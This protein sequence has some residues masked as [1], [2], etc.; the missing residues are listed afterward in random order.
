MAMLAVMSLARRIY[1]VDQDRFDVKPDRSTW[2]EMA[3]VLSDCGYRV[4]ILTWGTSGYQPEGDVRIRYFPAFDMLWLFRAS[5]LLNIL[6]WL[7]RHSSRDDLIIIHP[8]GLYIA[9]VLRLLGRRNIHL[10]VRTVPVEV[11]SFKRRLDR[12]LYWELPMRFLR[13]AARGHSFITR[14]L[15]EMVEGEFSVTIRDFSIWSSGV[16]TRRFSRESKATGFAGRHTLF[17]HGTISKDRGID[18]VVL[19]MASISQNVRRRIRFVLVGD[20]PD[21]AAIEQLASDLGLSE[22]VHFA[23]KHPY[24][25]IPAMVAD[26]SVCICPLPDRPEWNVSSPIKVFEFMAAGRPMILTPIPAHLDVAKSRDFVVWTKGDQPE[27]YR[28]AIEH[29]FA[30]LSALSEAARSAPAVAR[31]SFDW[32][33]QGQYLADY[34]DKKFG[35]PREKARAV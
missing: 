16:N 33:V 3:Q 14:R 29:A 8:D 13:R 7:V 9:P 20:G 2:I 25:A 24:E 22:I 6:V 1:W 15:K 32:S 31:D 11:N 21:V 12:L 30:N 27:D 5:L 34:L 17:Y 18:R 23:G 28:E 26:A 35:L 10:D 4:E 19:A